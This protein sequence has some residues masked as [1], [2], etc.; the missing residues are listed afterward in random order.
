MTLYDFLPSGN[1]YKVR[2]L[3]RQLSIPYELIEMDITRGETRTP[4]FLA[5][6]PNGRIPLIELEDGRFL[7]E[8]GAI[9]FYFAEGTRFLPADRYQRVLAYQWLFNGTSISAVTT[10]LLTLNNVGKTGAGSYSVVVTN[11]AG[12]VTSTVAQLTVTLPPALVQVA[13][14][15][16]TADGTVTLPLNLVASGTENA[17]GFTLNFDPTLLTYQGVVLGTG[18]TGASLLPN[19]NQA[20]LGHLGV[21]ISMPAGVTLAAGTQQVVVVTFA[22]QI[23]T[24]ATSTSIGF[25][26]AP[27]KRQLS[28]VS[29]NPLPANYSS[30]TVLLPA[31]LF[32]GDAY[33]RPNGDEALS[34]SDWVLVGR[35]VA[36]LDSPTNSVEFQK[37]DCAPRTTLGDG[38]L[39]VSDWVQAGRFAAGLDPMTRVGGPSTEVPAVL[40]TTT[41]SVAR[42]TQTNPRQVRIVAPALAQGQSGTVEVELEAQGDENALAFSLGFDP[43]QLVFTGATAGDSSS[44]AV[45]NINAGQAAQGH[46]GVVLAL[47]ANAI[48]AAGSKQLVKAS[49]RPTASQN[50]SARIFFTD[51]PN[52][53]IMK[54]STDGQITTFLQPCGRANGLYFD[55]KGNLLA[56]A[57]EKNALWSISPSKQVTVLVKDYQGKLLNGPNDLWVRPDDGILVRDL[58]ANS[59]IDN[60][61]EM[62]GG[63]SSGFSVMPTVR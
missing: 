4:E 58:N 33:P 35:Y 39:T 7:A 37:A 9:L 6:N 3:L 60:V 32:E 54:W 55:H 57:D 29:G 21:A 23:L 25:G 48:F 5:K 38:A 26:D 2:L 41:T 1:G 30:G 56:C 14:G 42:K 19:A 10:S 17:L 53:R 52:D 22:S 50:G 61:T 15:T 27:V 51:Q 63:A 40:A 46:L 47:K 28:D 49:F 31:S 16:S 44:G 8:S 34:I 43:A 13:S 24:A 36:R 59:R 11:T 20:A 18:T 62:F 12:S 45:L